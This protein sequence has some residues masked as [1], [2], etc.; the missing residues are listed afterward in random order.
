[1]KGMGKWGE[2]VGGKCTMKSHVEESFKEQSGNKEVKNKSF[3]ISQWLSVLGRN[4]SA[5]VLHFGLFLANYR[6]YCCWYCIILYHLYTVNKGTPTLACLW[7]DHTEI[8]NGFSKKRGTPPLLSEL[9]GDTVQHNFVWPIYYA[10][11]RQAYM[12]IF[13]QGRTPF[14]FWSAQWVPY[15]VCHTPYALDPYP[16]FTQHM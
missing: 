11:Q 3:I 12:F 2:M 9:P 10:A 14:L 5:T 1:M 13:S 4:I 6:H 8:T 7:L 16:P 15:V